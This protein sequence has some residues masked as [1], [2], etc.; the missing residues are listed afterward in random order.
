MRRLVKTGI[1]IVLLLGIIG[2]CQS[3]TDALRREIEMTRETTA[4]GEKIGG[5]RR[6]VLD[7][8]QVIR[9]K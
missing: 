5:K 1:Y 2:I 9:G 3:M 8:G 7:S 4:T 6:V